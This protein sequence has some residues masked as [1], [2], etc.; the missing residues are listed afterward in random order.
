[1]KDFEQ[2]PILKL[3][4]K[5]GEYT[6]EMEKKEEEERLRKELEEYEKYEP[7]PRPRDYYDDR[8]DE[9]NTRI[10]HLN[11]VILGYQRR[12]SFFA[13]ELYQAQMELEVDE[14]AFRRIKHYTNIRNFYWKQEQWNAVRLVER[15]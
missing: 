10:E 9:L 1:L 4:L 13:D 8:Y 7:P 3:K 12:P 6:E 11:S 2:K 14:N 15:K 5:I